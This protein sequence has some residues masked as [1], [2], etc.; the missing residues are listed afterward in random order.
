M[1]I[2]LFQNIITDP[3]AEMQ[4]KPCFQGILDKIIN[5]CP[6]FSPHS[7]VHQILALQL[8]NCYRVSAGLYKLNCAD[9]LNV[10]SPNQKSVKNCLKQLGNDEIGTLLGLYAQIN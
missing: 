3:F 1:L 5:F 6:E 9:A 4:S 10:D 7:A 8:T 2:C